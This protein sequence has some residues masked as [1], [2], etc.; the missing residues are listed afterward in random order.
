MSTTR[1]TYSTGTKP[2]KLKPYG[3]TSQRRVTV[4]KTKKRV[5]QT[6]FQVWSHEQI[7]K[8]KKIIGKKYKKK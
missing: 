4:K 5:E 3:Q 8:Y 1:G 2:K 6:P 7:P